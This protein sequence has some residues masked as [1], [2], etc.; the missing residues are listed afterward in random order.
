[1]LL[2]GDELGRTQQGNNNAYCQ[3]SEISWLDWTHSDE[4]RELFDFI[5]RVIRVRHAHPIFRR[6]TFF[7]HG[8]LPDGIRNVLWFGP[9][10]LE[11]SDQEWHQG[12]ARCL[13]MYLAGDAIDELD[14][15]GAPVIDDNFLLLINAHHE[16]IPF[17]LPGFQSNVRW[18]VAVDTYDITPSPDVR[19]YYAQGDTFPLQGRSLALLTQPETAA[20]PPPAAGTSDDLS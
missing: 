20:S 2:A 7:R 5:T 6:H 18:Q 10:G 14:A 11:M 19:R 13:G 8:P 1:M 15:H 16:E 12:F 4:S 3:D 9:D 17:V